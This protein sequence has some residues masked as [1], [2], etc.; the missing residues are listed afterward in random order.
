M[1]IETLHSITEI[2]PEDC[3]QTRGSFPVRVLCN[4]LNY[5]VC[6]YHAGNGFPFSLFNEYIAASFLKIWN[7]QVP[8]F[9]F[10]EIR[11]DHIY[12]INYPYYYFDNL[13][14]G[15]KYFGEYKEVDKFFLETPLIKK[16]NV[17]AR[18]SFLR[19]AMFDIWLSNEDRHYENFNL[20]YNLKSNHFVPIDH[21]FCFNSINLDNE[22]DLI[23]ENESILSSPFISRFFFR[24]L[25]QNHHDICSK[26]IEDFKINVAHCYEELDIILQNIPLAWNPD[27]GFLKSR[28]DFYFSETWLKTCVDYF[29]ILISRNIKT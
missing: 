3:Y 10:V 25:Q 17:I 8:E 16:E 15:S 22:P 5:Y 2:K 14:F 27:V 24:T 21:V 26:H 20:L 7:L 12:Q 29:T 28:L 18:D 9:A 23:S 4:D 19:I 6:K 1:K 13:C 11:N